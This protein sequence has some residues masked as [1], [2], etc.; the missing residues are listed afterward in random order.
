MCVDATQTAKAICGGADTPEVRKFNLA[1]ITHDH[2]FDVAFSI[3][4][5]AD[6]AP[7][8]TR[9]FAELASELDGDNLVRQNA[10]LIESF[11]APQ[12]I[13]LKTLSVA[14]KTSHQPV[15]GSAWRQI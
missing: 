4:Q 7:G 3:D 11:N 14:V 15:N 2:V 9:Q 13:W 5:G 10:T 6:L 8:L 12:L 1:R